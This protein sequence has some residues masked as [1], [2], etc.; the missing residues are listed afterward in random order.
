MTLSRGVF[1]LLLTAALVVPSV[2][3][4][5]ADTA[6]AHKAAAAALL[7]SNNS[8][9]AHWPVRRPSERSRL[10]IPLRGQAVATVEPQAPEEGAAAVRLRLLPRKAGTPRAVRCSKTST[11]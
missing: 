8:G 5:S 4:Q 3:A 6:T 7:N 10:R 1:P 9:A 11:C 2:L